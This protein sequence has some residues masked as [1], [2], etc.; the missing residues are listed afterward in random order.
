MA[1]TASVVGEHMHTT[2]LFLKVLYKTG[3]FS[4]KFSPL[5]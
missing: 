2:P 1:T 3:K 5:A 4:L